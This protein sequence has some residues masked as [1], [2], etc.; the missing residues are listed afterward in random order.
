M[1]YAHHPDIT[2]KQAALN[3][4]VF[5]IAVNPKSILGRSHLV[6]LADH[7]LSNLIQGSGGRSPLSHVIIERIMAHIHGRICRA[8]Y[9]F[10]SRAI[11]Q[12]NHIFLVS[13]STPPVTYFIFRPSQKV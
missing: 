13:T 12:R 7:R 11:I 3:T 10:L 9:S 2:P 5:Q 4:Q 6:T 8:V 1:H